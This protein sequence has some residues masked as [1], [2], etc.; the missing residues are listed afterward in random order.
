MGGLVIAGLLLSACQGEESANFSLPIPERQVELP[1]DVEALASLAEGC[2]TPRSALIGAC[3]GLLPSVVK[4]LSA[5]SSVGAEP[6]RLTGVEAAEAQ[7]LWTRVC[8]SGPQAL[9]PLGATQSQLEA[10]KM[11]YD[12]CQLERFEWLQRSRFVTAPDLV[13]SMLALQV[14]VALDGR[15]LPETLLEDVVACVMDEPISEPSSRPTGEVEKGQ[16]L[17]LYGASLEAPFTEALVT[18]LSQQAPKEGALVWINGERLWLWH[19]EQRLRGDDAAP[20]SL[21]V[22]ED[23]LEALVGLQERLSP[24]AENTRVLLAPTHSTRLSQIDRIAQSL[25]SAGAGEIVLLTQNQGQEL[26]RW[27]NWDTG[28][29]S[30]VE[31]RVSRAGMAWRGWRMGSGGDG[32]GKARIELTVDGE[33]TAK[34]FA[35]KISVLKNRLNDSVVVLNPKPLSK[36]Q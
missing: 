8:P 16:Y 9:T 5:Y 13:K 20:K 7:R 32:V 35:E 17:T 33:M 21:A 36:E 11:L 19:E 3:P 22:I 30:G 10:A 28:L 4:Q 23:S 24:G 31:L 6:P 18:T 14:F 2:E 29:R 15:G 1:C 12:I 25:K 34:E 27:L 26:V